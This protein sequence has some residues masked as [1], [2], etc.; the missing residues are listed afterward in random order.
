MVEDKD[1]KHGTHDY[2]PIIKKAAVELLLKENLLFK[3]CLENIKT[4]DK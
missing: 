3:A 2:L 1:K 4:L